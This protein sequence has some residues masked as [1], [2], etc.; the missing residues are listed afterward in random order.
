MKEGKAGRRDDGFITKVD[1]SV[2]R[3]MDIYIYIGNC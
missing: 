2:D 1:R 3:P